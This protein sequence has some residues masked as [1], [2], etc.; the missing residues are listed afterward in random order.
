MS[1]TWIRPLLC[2]LKRPLARCGLVLGAWLIASSAAAYAGNLDRIPNGAWRSCGT[3]HVSPGGGGPRNAFGQDFA[4]HGPWGSTL[5]AL[6]S[7]G[8]GYTNGQELL[9]PAGA[10]TYGAPSPGPSDESTD[11]GQP[12]SDMDECALG[13]DDCAGA[14]FNTAGGAASF[15]CFC[16]SGWEES[17]GACVDVNE[18]AV[19][20]SLCA[21][22]TCTNRV[23]SY[24]CSCPPGYRSSGG[25]CI[26]DPCLLCPA[27]STCVVSGETTSCACNPGF[28]MAGGAC[29]Y[30]GCAAPG[31]CGPDARACRQLDASWHECLCG[32]GEHFSSS[33]RTCVPGP[34][35]T[36][37]YYETPPLLEHCRD[38]LAAGYT[39]CDDEGLECVHLDHE[40]AFDFYAL[41]D[42]Y[43]EFEC[44]CTGF[45][46]RGTLS[47][48]DRDTCYSLPRPCVGGSC[49]DRFL[50][51]DCDCP[52]GQ[53]GRRACHTFAECDAGEP[54]CCERGERWSAATHTCV[55][56]DECAL[57][58][59]C[60]PG[61]TCTNTP[62]GFSCGCGPGWE[63]LVYPTTTWG[64]IETC[65][66]IDE[67]AEGGRCPGGTCVN[68]PGGFHCE[69]PAGFT[70]VG[71]SCVNVDECAE[72]EYCAPGTCTDTAGSYECDCPG[73]YE[74]RY[75]FCLDVDECVRDAEACPA[76]ARCVN[77]DGAWRCECPAG[78]ELLPGHGCVVPDACVGVSCAEHQHCEDSGSTGPTCVCDEGYAAEGTRCVGVCGDGQRVPPERCDDGNGAAG[79]GCTRCEIDPGW[80][81]REPSGGPS[82]CAPT[83]GDGL[84]DTGEECDD[85][86]ARSDTAPDACRTD[87]RRARCGDG[88]VDEG[89]GCDDPSGLS[90]TRPG[91]CR[92]DCRAAFCGDGVVDAGESCDPGGG[93]VLEGSACAS[94]PDAG[95]HV[96]P[97]SGGCRAAPGAPGRW[98]IALLL[99]GITALRRRTARR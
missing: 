28:M 45:D 22:G 79:D 43:A 15:L 27:N 60:G 89:E 76:D 71:G 95:P 38:T 96:P 83:C 99:L 87:C 33:L 32:P 50:G 44:T 61:N 20:P 26:A 13:W 47:C 53:A 46:Y 92:T 9:D 40:G 64:R 35:P 62:G 77:T 80:A 23:G 84:I 59:L 2:P 91:A 49:T 41:Y 16:P 81:C 30:A 21:P 4:A 75:G 48:S 25:A 57:Y 5:A 29:A 67:C 82:A 94:C 52:A 36:H 24:G 12:H 65:Q 97:A 6:D 86:D 18:C 42:S 63:H 70:A 88:V 17:A 11:P 69:C 39:F 72:L 58:D 7:D 55:D 54:D 34:R 85:G 90:D 51:Y 10:W 68:D 37:A 56:V 3:C 98:W 74:P 73:G 14:C 66:D 78:T 8:D 1:Y 31:A 93:A 19:D